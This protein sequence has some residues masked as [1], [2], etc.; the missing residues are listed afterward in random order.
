MTSDAFSKS[1][2]EARRRFLDA[3]RIAGA[4]SRPTVHPMVGPQN[5][6]LAIDVARLGS[7]DAACILWISS[8]TH[9]IEGYCGSAAQIAALHTGAFADLAS[10]VAVLLVHA[11]NPWGFAWQRRVNEDNVDLNRNF[12]DHDLPPPDNPIYDELHAILCPET[13]NE[14]TRAASKTASELLAEEYGAQ[15]VLEA[16]SRGQYAHA[17]GLFYGGRG[18]TW[19]NRMVCAI[20]NQE[21][22]RAR[23][24]AMVDLHTG[25]GP[26]GHG[27]PIATTSDIAVLETLR[28]W[29]GDEIRIPG[30]GSV[31][32]VVTGVLSDGVGRHTTACV[33]PVAL[34]FGTVARDDVRLALR[35]DNWLH[36][37]GDLDSEVGHTIKSQLRAAFY[38]QSD[39]WMSA[40][41]DRSEEIFGKALTGL[42]QIA[43]TYVNHNA[44]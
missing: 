44:Q 32:G 26:F 18:A 42:T 16:V 12:V 23:H 39:R 1:Y 28:D 33:L 36:C 21:L 27:E 13:W 7:P 35:A 5:E 6:E 40:V 29:Y 30:G 8:G 43:E 14:A 41:L 22:G 4:A 19:S 20:A 17:D 15:V 24:V 37:H 31:S 11:V 34:E 25:L 38:P 10:N 2:R 3:A 9:G